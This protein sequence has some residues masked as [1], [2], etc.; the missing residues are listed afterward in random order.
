MIEQLSTAADAAPA[1]PDRIA[2][3]CASTTASS[4]PRA[5][6]DGVRARVDGATRKR[7][8]TL[9]HGG[10]RATAVSPTTSCCEPAA[11]ASAQPARRAATRRRHGACSTPSKQLALR[12]GADAAGGQPVA[13][14]MV[15]LIAHR[16]PRGAAEPMPDADVA[17]RP[18]E[19]ARTS[20]KPV[21]LKP[22]RRRRRSEHRARR[23]PRS[24]RRPDA[25]A[26]RRLAPRAR[27]VVQRVG[28]PH[29]HPARGR[30][31]LQHQL[32]LLDARV[33]DAVLRIDRLPAVA[34]QRVLGLLHRRV[35]VAHVERDHQSARRRAATDRDRDRR[36]RV[37]DVERG[38]LHLAGQRRGRRVR[39]RVG[40]DD[41]QQVAA[42]GHR[43][44]VPDQDRI[45]D[46]ALA[47][48]STP[49][50]L[51]GGRARRRSARRGSRPRRARRTSAAPSGTCG[52][53]GSASR[54]PLRLRCARAAIG[55]VAVEA[56]DLRIAV[57][58]GCWNTV[59]G[60]WMVIERH[61]R[62]QVA[63]QVGGGHRRQ[64]RDS[65]RP[66][67]EHR[68]PLQIARA[69]AGDRRCRRASV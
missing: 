18:S 64:Q 39:R 12:A 43:R 41:P 29:D 56:G 25:A 52:G 34:V 66:P 35:L 63:R 55:R 58:N 1:N 36:R 49:S 47:A 46:A 57:G 32:E 26:R 61:P 65:S 50:R 16:R 59:P 11:T 20:T 5:L 48:A 15:W 62:T 7:C 24:Q 30:F 27:D 10:R 31:A 38:A 28:R 53:R 42:V 67:V 68:A 40:G 60:G 37:V 13:V 19:P 3:R 23:R 51:R 9:S 8:S 69:R 21:E 14:N 33:G 2:T 44:R 4:I 6:D 45:G 54:R 17:R 22:R